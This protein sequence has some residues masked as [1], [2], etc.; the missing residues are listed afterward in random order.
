MNATER[1]FRVHIHNDGPDDGL[2]AEVEELPGCFASGFTSDELRESLQEAIGLYLSSDD[3]H[4]QVQ[5][6]DDQEVESVKEQ[7]VLV[8]A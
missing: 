4:V 2:W 5:F 7:H 6:A 1:T 8:S 3:K